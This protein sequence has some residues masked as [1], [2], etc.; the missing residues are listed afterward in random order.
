MKKTAL[1]FFF[2]IISVRPIFGQGWQQLGIGS[3]KLGANGLI[4]AITTDT[5][6]IL[7]AAGEFT[8]SSNNEFVA[9]WNGNSWVEVGTGSN[10][11]NAV[12]EISSLVLDTNHILYA[13]GAFMNSGGKFYVAKW[14]GTTW[15]ELGAG[16]NALNANAPINSICT[17]RFGNIYAAG[18]FTDS[19]YYPHGNRYV[20]K[21]NGTSWVQL[22]IGSTALNADD[23]IRAIA[24]DSAGNLYA[25]GNFRYY[26][27]GYTYIAKWNGT[28]WMPLG[29]TSGLLNGAAIWALHFDSKNNL[30]AGGF[31]SD[32]SGH[33]YVAK[34]NGTDWSELGIASTALNTI[35]ILS[36]TTDSDGSVYTTGGS[37]TGGRFY[38]CKWNGVE[39]SQLG[40]MNA[41]ANAWC[42]AT[43]IH[44]NIFAS[45]DFTDSIL[46]YGSRY[47]AKY[48]G[49]AESIKEINF[50][51]KI[52]I[53]PN[54]VKDILNIHV[55][56]S[57]V[58]SSFFLIDMNGAVIK[59]GIFSRN[60]ASINMS[61][62]SKG[63]YYVK[64]KNSLHK[65]INY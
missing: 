6:N 14:D 3:D 12:G 45:G 27:G 56:N 55:D 15:S 37:D 46:D 42:L 24:T 22:G 36:I 13:A 20:A 2:I 40:M 19:P 48:T 62:Y 53:Y 5:G 39:W 30:Y 59:E 44:N 7:Y 52:C 50:Q 10:S 4:V 65:I 18:Q 49:K 26:P 8:N 21:W 57:Y 29:G 11:L 38:I 34:W 54:P 51:G 64:V 31:F 23:D 32:L 58:G 61:L 17:D 63:V 41:N 35:P 16:L 43:D 47:V 33:Y 60:A 25:A 9:K 28:T 1:L